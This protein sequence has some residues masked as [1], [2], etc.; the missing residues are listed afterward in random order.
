MASRRGSGTIALA[1][2]LSIA[3]L[4]VASVAGGVG[5]P[6]FSCK[7][8]NRGQAAVNPNPKGRPPLVIGDSTVNLPV[9]N[10]SQAG[11]DV[12]ARGCRGIFEA[13]ELATK[14]RRKDRLPH[15]VL[16]NGYANG[17]IKQ[18]QVDE[19][20]ATVGKGRVVV[21][22]TEYNADTGKGA[23]PDTRELF[24]ARRRYPHRIAVLDWVHFSGPHHAAEPAPGA[25]F[26]PDLFH[27]NFDGAAAYADFLSRALPLAKEGSFPPLH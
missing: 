9:S 5:E 22:L 16:M 23:A 27:P 13:I 1:L 14:L 12:N 20:I 21:L 4:A 25:W 8:V 24:A 2:A 10:L 26:L 11:F 17:G 7:Q 19:L 15:L 6:G 3:S 18:K